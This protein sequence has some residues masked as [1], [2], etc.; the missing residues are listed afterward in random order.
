[1][2]IS[3]VLPQNYDIPIGGYKIVYQYANY[4]VSQGH[5]VR[6]IFLQNPSYVRKNKIYQF[7]RYIYWSIFNKI[8]FKKKVTWFSLDERIDIDWNIKSNQ[9]QFDQHEK[10]I[11]TAYW[12]A[13]FVS[14]AEIP[15]K[16]KFYFLQDYEI[17]SGSVSS[18]DKTWKLPLNKF[19]VSSWLV[20]LGKNKFNEEVEFIPN[21]L[22]N[23]DDFKVTN[24][25]NNRGYTIA[26][27]NHPNKRKN[28]KLGLEIIELVRRKLPDIQ[29]KLFGTE[30][31][32]DSIY[33]YITYFKRPSRSQLRD[34]I[35]NKAKVYLLPS[36]YEGWGLT[37]MEAMASGTVVIS[38]DNGGVN[39]FIISNVNGFILDFNDE[40]LIVNK[41][42]DVLIS[43]NNQ[44]AVNATKIKNNFSVAK[45][46]VKLLN[47]LN[48]MDSQ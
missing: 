42:I 18:V 28:T 17:F 45:S 6:I 43:E 16:N 25:I 2:K 22:D 4:L 5:Q 41:I 19:A 44:I 47:Y 33:D 32:D 29:V 30:D 14:N 15:L 1:M 34:E 48:N 46:S 36:E 10:V 39:D 31:F 27:L 37:A 20:T 24:A 9:L 12:T 11:A 13:N 21:F 23:N 40:S 7:I 8:P 35:Y 3:W 38:N 26:L